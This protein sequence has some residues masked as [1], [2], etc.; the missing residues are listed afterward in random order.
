M[1]GFSALPIPSILVALLILTGP[2]SAW[3]QSKSQKF[4]C[5]DSD[6][7]AKIPRKMWA[8]IVVTQG[9]KELGTIKFRLFHLQVPKTVMNF[10]CLAEGKKPFVE[11]NPQ[12]GEVG[13]MVK[14][15]FYDGLTF[16][17]VVPGFMIQG[18][19]PFGTGRG[20]PVE[21]FDDE[22]VSSLRHNRPGIVSM[23]NSG[24]INNKGTNSTQF[25][26]TLSAQPDLNNKN[27]IF[28]QVEAGMNVVEKISKAARD[29]QD[30]P[31]I[32]IVMKSVRIIREF[33]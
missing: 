11:T 2:W 5:D 8:E 24:R 22:I 30:K 31:R 12:R 7:T 21:R 28:G 16:H 1:R 6:A 14:R 25:F 23:A 33:N 9:P 27:T 4:S 18:G 15:R 26:I 17:R 10:V 29:R 20:S 3:S 13:Q 32:P 19:C